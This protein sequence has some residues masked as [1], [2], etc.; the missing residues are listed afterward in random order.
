[1]CPVSQSWE[2]GELV[3]V[4][5]CGP[6]GT[7][8]GSDHPPSPPPP[9]YHQHLSLPG[10]LRQQVLNHYKH[11][12]ILQVQ[13]LET[14]PWSDLGSLSPGIR[15]QGWTLSSPSYCLSDAW[16]FPGHSGVETP[17]THSH[18]AHGCLA[19]KS[20]PRCCF[21]KAP[22]GLGPTPGQS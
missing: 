7:G 4:Q 13:R 10:Q 11:M 21:S 19:E 12:V 18:E 15:I 16:A 6:L 3:P 14:W 22:L 1:M 20:S 5:L 8:P 17:L 2:T 9:C